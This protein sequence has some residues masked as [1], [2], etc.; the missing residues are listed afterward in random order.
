MDGAIQMAAPPGVFS[1]L[2]R[3]TIIITVINLRTSLAFS[4]APSPPSPT[5]VKDTKVAVAG[6]ATVSIAPPPRQHALSHN[7]TL[8]NYMQLPVEQYVVIPMPLGSSLNRI[9]KS[10]FHPSD[11]IEFELV[12]PTISFFQLSLQPV[13]YATVQPHH[14]R[15]VISST[16]CVLCGSPFVE[17]VKLNDRFDFSVNTTLTWEDTFSKSSI[18][19]P[20]EVGCSITSETCI[21]VDVDVP[22]PFRSIPKRLLERAGN[23]AMKASLNYI[24]A[25]FV[26]NLAEDF[27]TWATNS[28]YRIYRASLL[29]K[30]LGVMCDTPTV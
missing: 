12:V 28:D 7:V 22:R 6:I 23:A 18:D 19:Q 2:V 8:T 15:V 29:S 17:K 3:L 14:N 16:K 11:C 10:T 27:K 26:D 13:V 5:R 24:Q 9:K 20:G 21:K 1:S 30:E 25:N 4:M